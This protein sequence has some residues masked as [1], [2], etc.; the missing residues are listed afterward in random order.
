[1]LYVN[2]TAERLPSSCCWYCCS[3][4]HKLLLLLRQRYGL[5]LLLVLLLILQP[6]RIALRGRRIPHEAVEIRVACR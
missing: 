3:K 2:L 5:L 6:S 4:L 1:M